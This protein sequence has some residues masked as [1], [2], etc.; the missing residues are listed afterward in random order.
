MHFDSN[1]FFSKKVENKK[2]ILREVPLDAH[3][4]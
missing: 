3:K 2:K 1:Y 4:P